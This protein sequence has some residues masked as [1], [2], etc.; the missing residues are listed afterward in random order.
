MQAIVSASHSSSYTSILV[1]YACVPEPFSCPVL[2][3]CWSTAAASPSAGTA[4]H[5]T[6][7]TAHGHSCTT[8]PSCICRWAC[9]LD[10]MLDSVHV[11]VVVSSNMVQICTKCIQFTTIAIPM[12]CAASRVCTAAEG[13][14][15]PVQP[16]LD[17]RSSGLGAVPGGSSQVGVCPR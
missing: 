7:A 9:G 10:M 2:T 16:H 8:P 15:E 1:M 14:A 4:S 3:V 6:W 11:Q 17:A 5:T 13:P 12:P